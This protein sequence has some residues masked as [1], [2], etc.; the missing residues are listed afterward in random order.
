MFV[1]V[2]KK[3]NMGYIHCKLTQSV[4]TITIPLWKLMFCWDFCYRP[5][6]PHLYTYL[7]HGCGTIYN[8]CHVLNVS[9]PI[10]QDCQSF[11]VGVHCWSM[12][13]KANTCQMW[14]IDDVDM[15]DF[16]LTYARRIARGNIDG[17][18][19]LKKSS[20]VT[21]RCILYSIYIAIAS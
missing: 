11:I 8:V 19:I 20:R 13:S 12:S 21:K 6:H 15:L 9:E 5:L 1:N 10:K 16:W 2:L 14:P 4:R 7:D 17:D 3:S 18:D